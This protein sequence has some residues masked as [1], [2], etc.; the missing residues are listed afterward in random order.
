MV[1]DDSKT[2]RRTAETLL[3]REGCEVVTASDGFEAL[4]ISEARMTELGLP[5]FGQPI[6][7]TCDNHGGTGMARMQQWDAAAKEWKSISDFIEPDQ[8]ILTPLIAADSEAYAKE[9]GIT[10]RP[11]S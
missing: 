8:E 9:N 10:P 1:I 2:I 7:I 11:C 5:G 3:K 4:D 6:K